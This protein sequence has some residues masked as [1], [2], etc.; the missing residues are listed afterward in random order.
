VPT[1]TILC[2]TLLIADSAIGYGLLDPDHRSITALI[3]AALGVL[4]VILGFLAHKPGLRK[5]TMHAA[6]AVGLLGFMAGLIRFVQNL[7][8]GKL[9]LLS[10]TCLAVMTVISAILVGL[11]INSFIQARKAR[12]AREQV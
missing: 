10:G 3:P 12:A 4:L 2:G 1:I 6:A 11:C 9:Q 7:I 5:H 8:T